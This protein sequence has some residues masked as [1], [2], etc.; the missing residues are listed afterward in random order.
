MKRGDVVEDFALPDQHGTERR[1]SEL[2][3]DGPVVLFFYPAAM[4]PGCTKEACHFRDLA[5]EFAAVGAQRVGISTDSVDKQARFADKE[6][7]DYPLLSDS[8]GAVATE[9][10]VKRGLLGKFMPVK[11]TTFVIDTDRRVLEV[12]ASEL[13]MDT[14]ADKALETLRARPATA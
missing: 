5:A 9:F 10:G 8:D 13:S 2:L 4:T 6:K 7:F 1:L 12:I 14:H 3:A 11:R